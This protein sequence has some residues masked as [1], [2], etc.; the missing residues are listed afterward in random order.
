MMT[1]IANQ[2]Q[3]ALTAKGL[4][5]YSAAKLIGAKSDLPLKT[6]YRRLVDM[7][8]GTPPLSQQILEETCKALGLTITIERNHNGT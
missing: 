4:T 3:A 1:T 7:T 8:A 5:L 6:V 2:L